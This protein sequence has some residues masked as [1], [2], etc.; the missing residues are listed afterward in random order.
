MHKITIKTKQSLK[1]LLGN[2]I[3]MIQGE[4]YGC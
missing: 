3:M 1:T 4:N 2:A